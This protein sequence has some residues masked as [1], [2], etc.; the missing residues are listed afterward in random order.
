MPSKKAWQLPTAA[1]KIKVAQQPKMEAAKRWQT[2]GG[3]Q[4]SQNSHQ[5]IRKKPWWKWN[6]KVNVGVAGST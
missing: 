1:V 4:G 6:D 3:K 2:A 5:A